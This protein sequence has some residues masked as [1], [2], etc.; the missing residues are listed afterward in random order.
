MN[1]VDQ[2]GEGTLMTASAQVV[3]PYP[4]TID[5]PALAWKVLVP[6]CNRSDRIRLANANTEALSIEAGKNITLNVSSLISSLPQNLLD[7][8]GDGAPSPLEVLLQT[9]LDP[10]QNSTVFISGSHQTKTLPKWLPDILSSL[11]IPFPLPHIDSNTSDLISSIHCSE[12]SITF[13]S[14]WAPPGTPGAQPKVS[15]VIEAVIR[16][17]KEAAN[18][19][20]NV[21]AVMTDIFLLDKGEK[22]GRVVVPE[23]TPATTE[24]DIMIHIKARV[25][26]V[27]IEVIDPVVFQRVMSKVLRGGGVVKIGVQGTVD[28][29]VI[30]LMGEFAVRGIPV[31]GIVEIEGI[32][33]FDDLKLGLVG[34]IEV[35]STTRNTITLAAAAHV[36]N[37]TEYEA[38]IPY[39]NL[40]LFYEG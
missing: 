21:T 34:D 8:C 17:P 25:A 7:P 11:A 26:E 39:L 18:V 10:N 31:Q 27:P 30:L 12:M 15:G 3:N 16:P 28:A 1:V 9:L 37:P 5:V 40:H 29:K 33:P 20:I 35:V 36:N 23:W 13:P 19:D 6:G 2:P 32:Y 22:F 38:F 4:M 14:P 24:R